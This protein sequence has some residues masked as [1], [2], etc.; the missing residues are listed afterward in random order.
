MATTTTEEQ[1]HYDEVY[2]DFLK[3][4][5]LKYVYVKGDEEMNSVIYKGCEFLHPFH[6]HRFRNPKNKKMPPTSK[7]LQIFKTNLNS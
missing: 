3:N 5:I 1:K 4:V 6:Y 7:N 2:D